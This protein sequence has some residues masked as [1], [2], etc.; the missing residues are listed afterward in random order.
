MK[1]SNHSLQRKDLQFS[2]QG[3]SMKLNVLQVVRVLFLQ[4]GAITLINNS[5]C[6]NDSFT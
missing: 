4:G 1:S 3:F 6:E 5:R 2:E